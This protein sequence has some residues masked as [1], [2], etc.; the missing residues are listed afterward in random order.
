MEEIS[1]S[2]KFTRSFTRI[3]QFVF[4]IKGT[5]RLAQLVDTDM[6]GEVVPVLN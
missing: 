6:K 2:T 4:M 1:S 3:G 5:D